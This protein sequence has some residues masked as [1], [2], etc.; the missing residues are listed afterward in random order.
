M[1]IYLILGIFIMSV[2]N[3]LDNYKSMI[4]YPEIHG[5][6]DD[7]LE[8]L[9]EKPILL[10]FVNTFLFLGSYLLWP[11]ILIVNLIKGDDA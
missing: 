6:D 11:L 8:F 9:K 5:V 10:I 4:K 7:E 1:I 2:F 3:S